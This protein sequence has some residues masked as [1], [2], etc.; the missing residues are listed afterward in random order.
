MGL[1]HRARKE[2]AQARA[3]LSRYLEAAPQAPDSALIKSYMEE[4]PL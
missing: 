4:L 1:I 3:S 2:A